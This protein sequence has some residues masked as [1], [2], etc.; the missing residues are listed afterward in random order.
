MIVNFQTSE[1]W[2]KCLG[3][4]LQQVLI[5]LQTAATEMNSHKETTFTVDLCRG[6]SRQRAESKRMLYIVTKVKG[7]SDRQKSITKYDRR[8]IV[9]V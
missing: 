6:I 1:N 8:E 4:F 2:S 7:N 3:A 9:M 5:G